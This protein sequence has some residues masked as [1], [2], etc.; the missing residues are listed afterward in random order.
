VRLNRLA[1]LRRTPLLLIVQ[2]VLRRV[3]FRPLDVGKLCFLRL[4]EIPRVP[5]SLLRGSGV[6]R[7]GTTDDLGGLVRLCGQGPV[8]LERFAEGDCCVVAEVS[9]RIVGYEWFCDHGVHRETGWGYPIVVP[10]GCL[11]A[12]DAYIAPPYRNSGIWLRFKA[13]LGDLMVETGKRGVLTFVDYGNW[14]SLRTHLRFGFRPDSEVLVVKV[15][16]RTMSVTERRAVWSRWLTGYWSR[17]RLH[18]SRA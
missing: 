13:F 7:R 16:G 10:P 2:K 3:P 1:E 14:P 6:V 15:L 4:D 8:F 12:Y 9:G 5:R 11:Y 18:R 17:D